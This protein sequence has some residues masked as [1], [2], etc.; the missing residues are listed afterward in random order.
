MTG[1]RSTTPGRLELELAGVLG[2]DRALAVERAAERVDHTAEQRVADGD[3][4]DA[5]GPA[6][7]LPLA[8]V[9][10]L[11][12]ERGADVVLLQVER[13]ADDAVLELEHLQRDRVLEPVHARDAVADLQDGADLGQVRLD[14]E[15][16]DSLLE[17]RGDLFRSELQGDSLSG[18]CEFTAQPLQAAA[19]TGV[20]AKGPD[21]QD[22]PAEQVGVDPPGGVDAAAARLL[23]L[24]DDLGRLLVGQLD[25]GGELE[26]EAP[27]R[28]GH[29][30]V[31]LALRL[32]ELAPHGRAR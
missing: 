17:D 3:A 25:R 6:D 4:G 9:L 10:P 18:R 28:L 20:E 24:P 16:L 31:E 1:C 8:D 13:E 21:L 2:L 12:E 14:V 7:G 29:E 15:V 5:A 32:F 30:S 27:G 19:K 22:D 23:D 11:A 26:R